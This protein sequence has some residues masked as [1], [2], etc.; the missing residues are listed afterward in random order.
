[1]AMDDRLLVTRLME[2]GVAA[3]R[4]NHKI[5]A[6]P[7]DDPDLR[8]VGA[9]GIANWL[10]ELG[11]HRMVGDVQPCFT[12][13]GAG[14][15]FQITDEAMRL[16]SDPSRFSAWL[17]NIFPPVPEYD[18]FISY[19]SA[20]SGV[21]E[22]L[23]S[24]LEE[25]NLRCFMAE[26]DIHVATDFQDSIRKALQGSKRILVLLTPR[27]INRPWVL[28]EVG[29]AWAFGKPLIPALSH[30]SPADLV[31]PIRRYQGR[32]IETTA[33]RQALVRELIFV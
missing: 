3:R 9:A 20:D 17:D 7:S 25:N 14:F 16:T 32:V 28:M 13:F 10:E 22:E 24:E 27:S 15:E 8:K 31:D 1:M 6:R 29:A 12:S 18:V 23:R 2:I 11:R 33:Q 19:A 26:K 21:A 4:K 30:V 5:Y